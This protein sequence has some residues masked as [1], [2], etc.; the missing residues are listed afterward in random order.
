MYQSVIRLFPEE[1][2]KEMLAMNYETMVKHWY[3]ANAGPIG[4]SRRVRTLWL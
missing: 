1:S 2:D 4:K 3:S